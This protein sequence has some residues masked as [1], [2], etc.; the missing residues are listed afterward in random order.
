MKRTMENDS[1]LTVARRATIVRQD[2][3]ETL[4]TLLTFGESMRRAYQVEQL[5]DTMRWGTTSFG[6]LQADGSYLPTEGTLKNYEHDF[7]HVYYENPSNPFLPYYSPSLNKWLTCR[8]GRII[9]NDVSEKY[10]NRE[11]IKR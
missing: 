7:G 1:C 8:V 2:A 5:I 6:I 10:V 9:F 4:G 3:E 11:Q